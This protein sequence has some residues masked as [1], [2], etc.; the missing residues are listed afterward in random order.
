MK[1]NIIFDLLFPKHITC[2]VCSKDIF[3]EGSNGIC[4]ECQKTLPKIVGQVCFKCG[5]PIH[6]IDRYCDF[7]KKSKPYEMAR[8]CYEYKGKIVTLIHN[9]KFNNAQYL[10]ED[11]S[12]DLCKLYKTEKYS[13]DIVIPVP[14]T[15]ARLKSRGYNQAGLLA[16]GLSKLINLPYDE[17][18]LLKIKDT[19]SQVGLDF[20]ERK[21]NLIDAFKTK[22]KKFFKGKK[23][24]LVDDIFTTGATIECC[25]RALKKGG[26][27]Q[28]FAITVAHTMKDFDKKD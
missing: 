14:M 25:A 21:N 20:S 16:N 1:N 17:N 22:D 19:K 6:S 24:L 11:F 13:C 15:Q 3:E 10:A 28:V 8:S 26:A 7:C 2:N 9:L 18:N 12:K 23:V 4:S 5:I 27:S